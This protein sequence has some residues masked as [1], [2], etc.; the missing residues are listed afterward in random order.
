VKTSNLFDIEVKFLSP[1]VEGVTAYPPRSD[2]FSNREAGINGGNSEPDWESHQ[3]QLLMGNESE[4]T[5]EPSLCRTS[6][7]G[8]TGW[9]QNGHDSRVS[10]FPTWN[11]CKQE[12]LFLNAPLIENP[13]D[14]GTLPAAINVKQEQ[15]KPYTA[16]TRAGANRMRHKAGIVPEAKARGKTTGYADR[17]T[18]ILTIELTSRVKKS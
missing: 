3:A 11:R 18:G 2:W 8:L 7:R 17:D 5:I 16:L 10:G 6:Q 13:A 12:F 9:V 14:S 15:G 1:Q 4:V